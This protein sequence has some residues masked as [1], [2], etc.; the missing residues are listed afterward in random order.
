MLFR[1]DCWGCKAQGLVLAAWRVVPV[2]KKATRPAPDKI[3]LLKNTLLKP[4]L[5]Y[6]LYSHKQTC[7]PWPVK[8]RPTRIRGL[9][10]PEL[11]LKLRPILGSI[12]GP[13]LRTELVVTPCRVHLVAIL[14]L[15]T[16]ARLPLKAPTVVP[17]ILLLVCWWSRRCCARHD[18][19]HDRGRLLRCPRWHWR[20]GCL[21]DTFQHF[22]NFGFRSSLFFCKFF[23]Q[24][25]LAG[26]LCFHRRFLSGAGLLHFCLECLKLTALKNLA[27]FQHFLHF[28]RT[29][30]HFSIVGS[31]RSLQFS[32]LGF[33]LALHGTGASFEN[34]FLLSP[35][36]CKGSTSFLQFRTEERRVGKEWSEPFR[37]QLAPI[38]DRKRYFVCNSIVKMNAN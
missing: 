7:S 38:S 31:A 18:T 26:L 24:L 4:L 15:L 5:K 32:L 2:A 29:S 33:P 35:L 37:S 20:Y 28:G 19:R 12:L 22:G 27:L 8:T 30:F 17:A 34:F 10:L 36:G 16:H 25:F 1:S 3:F 6:A 14:P 11:W 9:P 23:G 21:A 13:K